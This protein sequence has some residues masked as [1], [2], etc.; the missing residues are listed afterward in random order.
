MRAAALAFLLGAFA[1]ARA[2]WQGAQEGGLR[3]S[4]CGKA[5]PPAS[6]SVT[7]RKRKSLRRCSD[8]VV[9]EGRKAAPQPPK[10][11]PPPPEPA[12]PPVPAPTRPAA[13]P[14]AAQWRPGT[15]WPHACV[16]PGGLPE[17]Y[18]GP[19]LWVRDID[20]FYASLPAGFPHLPVFMLQPYVQQVEL[21]E[22]FALLTE[23]YAALPGGAAL[24]RPL[25]EHAPLFAA[26]GLTLRMHDTGLPV[27]VTEIFSTPNG[28][29]VD[30]SV[31][32]RHAAARCCDK[33]KKPAA[34]RC[35]CGEAY[36]SRTCQAAHWKDHRSICAAVQDNHELGLYF[37]SIW[38]AMRGVGKAR[39]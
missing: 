18:P 23:R 34:A 35:R 14:P 13:H 17:L 20:A 5:K 31:K 1:Y 26:C 16:G 39:K 25:S 33:C 2:K 8:C 29:G 7:Q 15:P 22:R 24:R 32:L 10:P 9:A 21:D 6:F 4:K 38:W 3:C 19:A 36:C 28:Y 11:A 12:P 27:D 37:N 30:F